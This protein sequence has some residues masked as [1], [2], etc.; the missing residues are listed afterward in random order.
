MRYPKKSLQRYHDVW[1]YLF[2]APQLLGLVCFILLPVLMSFYLAFA[3][4]DFI[5]LPYF[6]GLANFRTLFAEDMIWKSLWSTVILTFFILPLTIIFSLGLAVAVNNLAKGTALYR[7]V[8]FLPMVT[9]TVAISL[10]WFWIYAPDYGIL[11]ILFSELGLPEVLWLEERIPARIALIVMC[12]WGGLG[13]NFMIFLA[14]LKGIPRSYYEA[15]ELD[16][17]KG[18]RQFL[19]ITFPLVSPTTFYVCIITFLGVFTIF[20]QA[21]ML[22]GGGPEYATYTIM[23]YMYQT[24]FKSLDMGLAAAIAMIIAIVQIVVTVIQFALSKRWVNYE[25]E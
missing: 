4:W 17:A 11:N 7:L 20:N 16:G 3:Q 15:A 1:G 22:T 24:A 21:Y 12:V 8:I 14:G 9:S 19:S 2:I 10:V 13:T 25:V 18:Y 5:E 6:V 23:L